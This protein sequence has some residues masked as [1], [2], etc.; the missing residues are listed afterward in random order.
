MSLESQ[1]GTEGTRCRDCSDPIRAGQTRC[2]K[3]QRAFEAREKLK[4]VVI[5]KA[6]SDH[7]PD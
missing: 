1:P 5:R 4:G 2:A 6:P 7:G 3:C